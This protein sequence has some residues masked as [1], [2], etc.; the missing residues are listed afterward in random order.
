MTVRRLS[1]GSRLSDRVEEQRHNNFDFIRWLAAT[2][3]II[4]HEYAIHSRSDSEPLAALTHGFI[5]FGALGVDVFFVISGFLVVRSMLE[6]Q[7]LAFF[8]SSRVLRLAPGLS[9][10]LIFSAFVLGPLLTSLPIWTY[11]SRGDVYSYVFNNLVFVRSQWD[12]PGLFSHNPIP[13]VVNGSLWSSLARGPDVCSCL[14][15]GR[16]KS[17]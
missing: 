7:S 11:F 16:R 17:P 2:L 5:T 4:S 8:A 13:D 14:R 15:L 9:V 3:V 10:A 12:L 1:L 6:R